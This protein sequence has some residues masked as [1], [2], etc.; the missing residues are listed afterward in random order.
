MTC[1]HGKDAGGKH[2]TRAPRLET[3]PSP[4]KS[5]INRPPCLTGINS[6]SRQ[7]PRMTAAPDLERAYRDKTAVI[8]IVGMGYVGIPLALASWTAGFRVVGFDVDADKVA[9][10]NAGKSYIKHIPG[11]DVAAA[12]KAGKLRA[13]TSFG[14]AKDVDAILI[15]VPTPLTAH[16]EP[17]LSYVVKTTE[18]LAPHLRKGHLI[19]LESTTWPGTTAEIMKPILERGGLKSGKDFFLAFS[20]EREDPGNPTFSARVIPKVVGGDDPTALALASALYGAI[21]PKVIPVSSTQTAEAV[22]LTENI[23][24]AVN[25]ALVNELKVVYD[26]MGIDVWEVIDAAKTKPFGFMPFYPGPGL[27]G[28]CIPIDP[29]YLS[30]KAKQTGFDPRFIELAGQV[31]GGMPHFVV[32]KITDALNRHEKSVNGSS[33]LILGIAYKR[34]IDDMRESPSLDVMALLHQ[35]GARVRYADPYVPT[36]AARAWHGGFDMQTEP[37]TAAAIA[38]A[39]CVAILTEHRTVDYDMVLRSARLIVDTRNAIAG[40]HPH[41][42]KLGAPAPV[43]TIDTPAPRE[44]VLA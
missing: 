3:S 10:L 7:H 36:L 31:N 5:P 42:F 14:E 32:D 12:V 39:D 4:N 9:A 21:V 22:K 8:G 18:A 19:V 13:T 41:V 16:R 2:L 33:V 6:A 15:C 17:D 38:D 20:P 40:K 25:I 34:D 44:K 37:L 27:G 11:D 29:F 30:W 28:H 24:R 1:G 23:F 26:A 35:K 43:M